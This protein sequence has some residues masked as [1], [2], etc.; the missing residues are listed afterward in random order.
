MEQRG[1][2]RDKHLTPL[3]FA[4]NLKSSD[5]LANYARL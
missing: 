4:H 1:L 5:V 2:L 3:E